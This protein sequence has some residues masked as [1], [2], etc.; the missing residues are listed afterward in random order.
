[1]DVKAVRFI[2]VDMDGTL[3]NSK[4]EVS[5]RLED[6]LMGL[7]SLG[8]RFAAASGRQYASITEKLAHLSDDLIVIAENGAYARMDGEDLVHTTIDVPARNEVLRRVEGRL[9]IHPVLCTRDNAYI[10]S[11]RPDFIG[12][13]SEYYNRYSCVDDLMSIPD[14]VLKVALYQAEDS[15]RHIWPLMADLQGDLQVK[16]SGKYWVDVSH[17]LANKGHA[18]AIV[19]EKLGVS[20]AETMAFGDYNNDLEML[21]R[22]D[23]SFAMANAHPNV[24]LAAR[25]QAGGNDELGVERVL[26]QLL[27]AH[28]LLTLK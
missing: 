2:A 4:H 9:D 22:A 1:M 20:P 18:M 25:Y 5:D 17:P 11:D 28:G 7:R 24:K 10:R 14:P 16:V 27:Q 15:E 8:I 12:Y 13:V 6:L 21:A 19:Q 26:E 3:L 23:F